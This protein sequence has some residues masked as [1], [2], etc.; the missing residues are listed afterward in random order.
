MGI[1]GPPREKPHLPV[2]VSLG[3]SLQCSKS[4]GGINKGPNPL[5]FEKMPA[6]EMREQR[7][8]FWDQ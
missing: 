8:S 6:E 4:R 2:G 1:Q 7:E 5:F 3:S